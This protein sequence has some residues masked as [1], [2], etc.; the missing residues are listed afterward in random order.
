MSDDSRKTSTFFSRVRTRSRDLEQGTHERWIPVY[1]Y[2]IHLRKAAYEARGP[3]IAVAALAI[4]M[5][6][7]SQSSEALRA[8]A[9]D[10]ASE[11]WRLMCVWAG[12]G[13]VLIV[14]TWFALYVAF[15][16]FTASQKQEMFCHAHQDIIGFTIAAPVLINGIAFWR[17]G[18]FTVLGIMATAGSVIFIVYWS[19]RG[20]RSFKQQQTQTKES[21]Q[22]STDPPQ[23]SKFNWLVVLLLVIIAALAMSAVIFGPIVP[24]YLTI[25][26]SL[27]LATLTVLSLWGRFFG[28][29]IISL[30]FFWMLLLDFKDANDNHQVQTIAADPQ[31]EPRDVVAALDDWLLARCVKSSDRQSLPENCKQKQNAAADYPIILVAAEGGGM[32]AAYFTDLV[33]EELRARSSEFEKHLFL[34][35]GVSGG[36]VGAAAYAAALHAGLPKPVD[37]AHAPDVMALQE[38]FLSPTIRALFPGDFLARFWPGSGLAGLDRARGLETAFSG[39]FAENTSHL[40]ADKRKADLHKVGFQEI[41]SPGSVLNVPA[42]M[43]MT[44][45]VSSGHRMAVSH[46]KMPDPPEQDPKQDQAD[47]RPRGDLAATVQTTDFT[48]RLWTLSEEMPKKDLPLDTAAIL[49]ARFPFISPAG[50]LPCNGSPRR[51]VDGG[52]FENSGT[53]TVLDV[54]AAV[55]KHVAAAKA[56]LF[57]L[58]IEN[59][60]A[61]AGE[62]G[63]IVPAGAF[64][65]IMSPVRAMLHTRQARAE[66]AVENL[67]RLEDAERTRCEHIDKFNELLQRR[68]DQERRELEALQDSCL[69]LTARVIALRAPAPTNKDPVAIPLGWW[70]TKAAR[71]EMQ[72]QLS[73]P[74]N[75]DVLTEI[76]GLVDR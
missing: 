30:C 57:V 21:Q 63:S 42:L 76:T 41:Y 8:F 10:P 31:H 9:E 70:L 39:A 29:A 55:R 25:T 67:K 49:S 50:R 1:T 15:S 40:V 23:N 12:C 4:L 44:T 11:Q 24:I 27:A 43:L 54:I 52:Y 35:V 3:V 73:G 58:R 34:I 75:A 33:L 51:F 6:I 47:C 2:L 65:E 71:K 59:S 32:R 74:E 38:D 37:A 26:A 60:R 69:R 53:T 48:P 62:D 61:F 68:P 19:I 16:R 22:V 36:S 17:S 20:W 7:P 64:S 13:L 56:K 14:V 5:L 18:A 28:L 72:R 46:V 45:D 66:L